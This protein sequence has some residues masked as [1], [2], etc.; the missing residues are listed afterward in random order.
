MKGL[1]MADNDIYVATDSAHVVIDGEHY[2][3]VKG[4][5]RVR[6]GHDLI[7]THPELFVPCDVHYDVES[8]TQG[9]GERR[10]G[11]RRSTGQ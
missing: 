1:P 7:R 8:A 10:G 4:V 9:P 2:T 3:L 11:R 6:A 5:T